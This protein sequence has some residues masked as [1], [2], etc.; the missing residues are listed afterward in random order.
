MKGHKRTDSIWFYFINISR[1]GKFME[2]E[3][4]LE[5]TRGWTSGVE[6]LGFLGGGCGMKEPRKWTMVMVA[7]HYE[8]I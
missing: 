3:R 7:L 8:C 5:F 2:T 4:R 1:I 6:F